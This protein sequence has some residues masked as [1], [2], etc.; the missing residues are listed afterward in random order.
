MQTAASHRSGVLT[1]KKDGVATGSGSGGEEGEQKKKTNYTTVR[2]ILKKHLQRPLE[3]DVNRY[4]GGGEGVW[5][6]WD[7]REES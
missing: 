6:G 3:N 5:D 2:L 4:S 1:P 7:G